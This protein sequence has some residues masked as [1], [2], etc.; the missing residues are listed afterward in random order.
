M[1]ESRRDFLKAGTKAVAVVAAADRVR[2]VEYA[3]NGSGRKRPRTGCD[4]GTAWPRRRPH[5]VD[6]ERCRMLK[7]LRCAISM[8]T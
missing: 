3:A 8:T 2:V 1:D 6:M 7:L 5:S 4:R